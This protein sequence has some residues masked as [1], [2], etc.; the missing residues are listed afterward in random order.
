MNEPIIDTQTQQG[1]NRFLV[2][3][4]SYM[5]AALA[6]SAIVAGVVATRWG[7]GVNEYLGAHPVIYFGLLALQFGMVF[8]LS[9]N[10]RRS[11]VVS[12]SCLFIFAALEGLFF[13][14][15]LTVY[16]AT[17]VTMA[18]VAAA[19]MFGT[20]AFLGTTTSKNLA[21]W[22]R[23]AFAALIAMVI[24]SLVNLFLHSPIIVIILSLVG[25]VVFGVLSA[26][27]AQRIKQI[28]YQLGDEVAQTSGIITSAAL[29]LY[30]DFLNLFLELLNIFTLFNNNR[31]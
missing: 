3:V 1:L 22:G 30:L 8:A 23:Q 21:G 27:D 28:Y 6:V 13:S 16:A 12:V 18:F 17:N 7:N 10:P 25:V 31:D 19:V 2:R 9:F 20:L 4:Y 5:A 15:L 24:I 26:W 11:P 29:Q 14:S